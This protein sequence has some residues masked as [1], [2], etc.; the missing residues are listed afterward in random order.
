MDRR[1]SVV[2]VYEHALLGQ[3]LGRYLTSE[4]GLD[5]EYVPS[6]D[7]AAVRAALTI[8][9]DV[10]LFERVAPADVCN[11]MNLAPDAMYIDIS[12]EQGPAWTYRRQRIPASPEGIVAA[13]E[14]ARQSIDE[15]SVGTPDGRATAAGGTRPSKDAAA[16]EAAP[17][18]GG[19]A[20]VARAAH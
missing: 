4:P 5:I 1:L 2:V 19:A 18:V 11:L 14:R 16:R 13:I 3:G 7:L 15:D 6:R 8:S 9:P 20:Q 10:V 12:L 17:P